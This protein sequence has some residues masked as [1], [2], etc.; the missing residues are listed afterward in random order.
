MN[1]ILAAVAIASGLVLAWLFVGYGAFLRALV[2][3]RGSRTR[4]FGPRDHRVTVVLAVFNEAPALPARLRNL[5]D[6]EFPAERLSVV[7]ASDSST[8]GSDDVVRGWPDDRVRLVRSEP[9]GGKSVA[10]NAALREIAQGIVVITDCGTAFDRRTIPE[11]AAP[12]A[13]PGVGAVDGALRFSPPPG[14]LGMRAHGAYWDYESRVRMAESDLGI[15]ATASGAVMAAR[16]ELILEIPAHV[17]DDCVIPLM[18]VAA[19]RRVHRAT[20]ACAW[21]ESNSDPRAEFRAR[22]RMVVRNWQGTWMHPR[23]L[24]P[25]R[26]PWVSAGLWSHKVLR[27]CAP[28][29]VATG[30]GSL[31]FLGVRAG[32]AWGWLAAGAWSLALFGAIDALAAWRSRGRHRATALGSFALVCCAFAVGLAK[33]AMGH[34]IGGYRDRSVAAMLVAPLIMVLS[35]AASARAEGISLPSGWAS[36]SESRATRPDSVISPCVTALSP[37]GRVAFCAGSGGESFAGGGVWGCSVADGRQV[38]S[39]P[40]VGRNC[41]ALRIAGLAGQVL[42]AAWRGSCEITTI[43]VHDWRVIGGS[44]LDFVPMDAVTDGD[45]AWVVGFTQQ[46][47]GVVASFGIEGGVAVPGSTRR[48]AHAVHRAALVEGML[49]VS[50]PS[51][52]CIEWVDPQT[53]DVRAHHAVAGTPVAVAGSRSDVLVA[54]REGEFLEVGFAGGV[55][56]RTDLALAFGIDPAARVLRDL[57]PTDVIP[58]GD[59]RAIIGTYRVDGFVIERTSDG[60]RPLRRV[61]GAARH[62]LAGVAEGTVTMLLGRRNRLEIGSIDLRG[63]TPDVVR[64]LAAA[65]AVTAWATPSGSGVRAAAVTSAADRVKLLSPD[66]LQRQDWPVR[67]PGSR[68][69]ALAPGPEGQVLAV[70][71]RAEGAYEI[72]SFPSEGAVPAAP[73]PEARAPSWIGW[74]GGRALVIDRLLG[75]AWISAPEGV[76]ALPSPR[77]RPRAAAPLLDGSWIVIHDTNPDIGCSRILGGAWER[78][79]PLKGIKGWPS[80][81]AS[82]ADGRS[83][84]FVTFGGSLCEV[85]DDLRVRRLRNLG[86]VG[87]SS[88]EVD[89]SGRIGVVS[90]NAGAGMLLESFEAPAIEFRGGGLQ[91]LIPR[92]DGSVALVTLTGCEFARPAADGAR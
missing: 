34:R 43:D 69:A 56:R 57:D 21:D 52:S 74:S 11:L 5:L 63:G 10:Q 35:A 28:A 30:L 85:G 8:D 32:G 86:L 41:C 55:R 19:G 18:A 29:F 37:D 4:V 71:R 80:A 46:G 70:L 48:L 3:L 17:G 72:A 36:S 2:A 12:F 14:E 76:Q 77:S 39:L 20:A 44:R 51:G 7:V 92:P 13:D 15:L 31:A 45:R 6:T 66:P 87:A 83:A 65:D 64:T 89:S 26:R 22:V 25:W 33:V 75:T 79:M 49:V 42:L 78:F 23:L 9:R 54:T 61:P 59:D 53:L 62:T 82:A 27:W 60:V 91:A 58:L 73:L 40:G 67:I 47:E 68:I 24:A 38:G 16:R 90:E 88:I 81:I 50:Q 84:L 1:A